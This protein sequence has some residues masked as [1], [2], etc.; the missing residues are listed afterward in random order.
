MAPSTEFSL[1]NLPE[2]SIT[3]VFKFLKVADIVRA[4]LLCCRT[5]A[6][7]GKQDFLWEKEW[8]TLTRLSH[9]HPGRGTNLVSIPSHFK[10]KLYRL[11]CKE[12]SNRFR[13]KFEESL[14]KRR[15]SISTHGPVRAL[16]DLILNDLQKSK[17]DSESISIKL[18]Y[19]NSAGNGNRPLSCRR[20]ITHFQSDDISLNSVEVSLVN[21]VQSLK[22]KV[23]VRACFYVDITMSPSFCSILLHFDA[24]YCYSSQK[25]VPAI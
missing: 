3:Y 5:L 19:S 16:R 21:A 15:I 17:S 8:R 13:K 18:V 24:S 2:S 7:I 23:R 9:P 14:K 25:S 10:G 6:N 20:K 22:T 11:C 1:L 12:R 4:S